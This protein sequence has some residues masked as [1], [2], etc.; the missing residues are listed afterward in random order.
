MNNPS[1]SRLGQLPL[2]STQF[3]AEFPG[4]R[5]AIDMR[6]RRALGH[7]KYN[8]QGLGFLSPTAW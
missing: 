7:L 2:D 4:P 1:V 5:S 8:P 3:D 6:H